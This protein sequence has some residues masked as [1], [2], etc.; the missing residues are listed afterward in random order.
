M[1]N[2]TF[3]NYK[4][5]PI[6]VS[7][8]GYMLVHMFEYHPD[9]IEDIMMDEELCYQMDTVNHKEAA[10]QL[11]KQM[12]GGDCV[13]FIKAVKDRCDELLV[14][15]EERMKDVRDRINKKRRETGLP[16]LE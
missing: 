5:F 10:E 7:R 11:F 4:R 14:G 16:E 12:E 13:A 6:Q 8:T 3:T 2:N 9:H 1:E 15:H